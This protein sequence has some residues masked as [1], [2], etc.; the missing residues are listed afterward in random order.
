M[1]EG[2]QNIT[3]IESVDHAE[4][5]KK[6]KESGCQKAHFTNG[7]YAYSASLIVPTA[8]AGFKYVLDNDE[9]LPLVIAVNSDE[10]MKDLNFKDFESQT[11]RANK[12]ALPLATLFPE[13]QI[14]IIYYD[15]KTPNSLYEALHAEKMTATLHKWGYGT[16]P[17]AP[18]IEGAELFKTTYAYPLPND[19]KPVCHQ[20]T[21]V[22]EEAQKIEVVDLREKLI[23]KEGILF[24]VPAALQQYVSPT[25]ALAAEKPAVIFTDYSAS[26]SSSSVKEEPRSEANKKLTMS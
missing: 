9:A 11:I 22:S 14:Y 5:I 16:N 7:T 1:L 13:T 17:N 8:L 20:I 4:I 12:V 6:L 10:S 3:Y 26:A 21:P 15:E 18:K 19:I 24:D 2:P 23:V 25:V